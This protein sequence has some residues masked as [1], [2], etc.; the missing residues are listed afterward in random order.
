MPGCQHAHLDGS[1]HRF[2]APTLCRHTL[3]LLLL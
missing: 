3:L 2:H 1:L